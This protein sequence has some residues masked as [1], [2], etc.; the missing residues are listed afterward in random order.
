MKA[1]AY[2]VVDGVT[3]VCAHPH[4]SPLRLLVPG[5]EPQP[6]GFERDK[7]GRWRRYV[8]RR[9]VSRLFT[10]STTATW[11]GRTVEVQSV[12]DDSAYIEY[13]GVDFNGEPE[14]TVRDYAVW[15]GSVPTESLTDVTEEVTE[16]PL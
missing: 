7:A 16:V 2:A 8:E 11:R 6:P 10:V 12:F 13:R 4:A 1:G 3:Y 9:D 5:S 14:L 15:A